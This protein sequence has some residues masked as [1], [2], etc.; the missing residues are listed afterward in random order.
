MQIQK[1]TWLIICDSCSRRKW[2]FST[3]FKTINGKKVVDKS[4]EI[5]EYLE[6]RSYKPNHQ[7]LD[8]ETSQKMKS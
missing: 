6:E 8:N 2:Y 4:S 7:F 1:G 5:H 3:T